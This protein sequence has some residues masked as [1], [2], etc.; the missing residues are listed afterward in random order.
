V[1][2]ARFKAAGGLGGDVIG[3]MQGRG[4]IDVDLAHVA[5]IECA[6]ATA[7]GEVFPDQCGIPDGHVPG[8]GNLL[9]W[10]SSRDGGVRAVASE[11]RWL[12]MARPR[13]D[14]LL[15]PVRKRIHPPPPRIRD[16][17]R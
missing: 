14:R 9:F 16:Q 10:R 15:S 8:C 17:I 13:V 2:L 12:I 3:E 7:H 4:T 11:R 6:H 5:D 1:D